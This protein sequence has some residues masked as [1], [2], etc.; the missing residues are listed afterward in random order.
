MSEESRS[1]N[2]G[3][4]K[5]WRRILL[6]IIAITIHNIP[7]MYVAG[8][9]AGCV[10]GCVAMHALCSISSLVPRLPPLAY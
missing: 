9:A 7:G 4:E 5:S 3:A 1:T 10:A 2:D 8:C 6:L